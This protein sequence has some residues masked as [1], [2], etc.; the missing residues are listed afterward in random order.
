MTARLRKLTAV[1]V[2]A[3]AL[4]AGAC[5]VGGD[6]RDSAMGTTQSKGVYDTSATRNVPDS[7][8]GLPGRTGRPGVAG[9]SLAGRRPPPS[10]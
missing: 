1:A 10:P 4:V 8:T 6:V 2:S 3:A 7:T 9:D 5:Q